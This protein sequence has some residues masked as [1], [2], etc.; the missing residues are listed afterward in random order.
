MSSLEGLAEWQRTG[1]A[2]LAMGFVMGCVLWLA[3]LAAKGI[4]GGDGEGKRG[5]R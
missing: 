2:A 3:L 1:L 4:M 5:R